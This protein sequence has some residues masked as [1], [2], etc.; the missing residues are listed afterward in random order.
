MLGYDLISQKRGSLTSYYHYDGQLSTRQLSD[1]SQNVTDAYTYDAFGLLLN[2]SGSTENNYLYT[3]EQ[4]DPNCGFYYLRARYYNASVGRFLTM[5][6]WKGSMFEPY[7]LHKYLY[8]YN[9]PVNNIDPSGL[10]L[11]RPA[12]CMEVTIA[13]AAT[14][15][16]LSGVW[17]NATHLLSNLLG[18][19]EPVIWK[20]SMTVVTFGAVWGGG[21]IIAYLEGSYKNESLQGLYIVLLFGFTILADYF[22]NASY[23]SNLYLE[24]PGLFGLHAWVLTGP[25]SYSAGSYTLNFNGY[26]VVGVSVSVTNMGMGYTPTEHTA[27]VIIG[28]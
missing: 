27:G 18:Y 16:L 26:H 1:A 24:T 4:Y 19:K 11:G 13:I 14:F 8:C 12:T 9:E 23:S 7:S 6:T 10:L 28:K 25:S 21:A 22:V 15:A 20:G 17:V 2:R 5:D 3:G